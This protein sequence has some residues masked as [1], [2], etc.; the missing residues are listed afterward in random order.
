MSYMH[1]HLQFIKENVDDNRKDAFSTIEYEKF[2]RV[3][4]YMETTEY[5]LDKIIQGRS[6]FYNFFEEQGRRRGVD[7]KQVFPEMSDFFELCSKYV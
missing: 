6:D 7:H 1:D 2:R 5:P 3:V 4:D